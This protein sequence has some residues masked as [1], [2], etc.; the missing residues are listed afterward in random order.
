M[1]F[2]FFAGGTTVTGMEVALLSLMARLNA[3]GHRAV[4]IVS[5]WNDGFYAPMLD[6]AGIEHHEV[7][8]GRIYRS[9]P[10]W[11]RG[12]LYALREAARD[13]RGIAASLRPD[14]VILGEAQSLLFCSMI[15]PGARRALYLHGEP[16]RI[17]RHAVGGHVIGWPVRRL[18]CVS[19]FLAR[20]VR[21]TPLRRLPLS[22]VPNGTAIAAVDRGSQPA[23]PLRLA[24][25]GRISEQKRQR[26]LLEALAR[27]PK[28][29]FHLSIIGG[30]DQAIAERATSLGL[31]GNVSWTGFVG[32]KAAL[33]R[34]LDV[35]VAPA[36][37]EGFGM[38]VIEA[39]AH[40]LPTVAARSGAFPEVIRDGET[41]LLVEPDDPVALAD[42]LRRLITDP[43]LRL[44]LGDAARARVAACFTV[45]QMAD[46]F[47]AALS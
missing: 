4:A 14:W 32:D 34:D 12:T 1:K 18:L 46:R 8:L 17:M 20:K 11:T 16:E 9:N 29:S 3:I 30:T 6:A 13:I 23:G 35:V 44:R 43:D 36:V 42:A 33:Y 45:E 21:A 40:G 47:V 2:L 22:V 5:G 25:I 19:E 41:G 37:N 31:A 26:V 7:F 39:G 10:E 15:L 27:L 28:N 38:T 24:I